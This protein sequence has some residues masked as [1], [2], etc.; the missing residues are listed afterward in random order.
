MQRLFPVHASRLASRS[1]CVSVC[2]AVERVNFCPNLIPLTYHS[3]LS[4]PA[5]VPRSQSRKKREQIRHVTKSYIRAPRQCRGLFHARDCRT[6]DCHGYICGREPQDAQ[7]VKRPHSGSARGCRR[8]RVWRGGRGRLCRSCDSDRLGSRPLQTETGKRPEPESASTAR[9][10][11]TRP[12][13]L[14][15]WAK[16]LRTPSHLFRQIGASTTPT[17]QSRRRLSPTLSTSPSYTLGQRHRLHLGPSLSL[18]AKKTLIFLSRDTRSPPIVCGNELY[19][20]IASAPR[21]C[22]FR[23][24]LHVREDTAG[25]LGFT[26]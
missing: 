8:Q 14:P 1:V 24:K 12:L 20:R 11:R 13:G 9:R 5:Y 23:R 2:A 10:A 15:L 17:R 3:L 26:A 25:L 16:C 19:L 4:F 22:P 7:N 6:S 18:P 21:S